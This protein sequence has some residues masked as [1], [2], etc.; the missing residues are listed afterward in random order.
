MSPPDEDDPDA[1]E[2]ALGTLDAAE[3]A[4]ADM[5]RR[6]DRGFDASVVQWEARLSPLNEAF[7]E[8]APPSHLYARLMERLFGSGQPAGGTDP[9]RLMSL[10]R[11]V[12]RW[13]LATGAMTALAAALLA[14]VLIE[15]P[16]AA[17]GKFVA[18]LQRDANSPAM[19]LDVDIAARR[20]TIRPVS[21]EEPADKS[22]QL[23]LINPEVGGARS[24]GL[25]SNRAL[26]QASL[27]DYDP[28]VIARATYAVTLEPLGGSPT[29]AP[30]GP[31]ILSG[32]LLNAGH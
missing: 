25:L 10:T 7:P 26:T 9:V 5:R 30:S 1:A 24:L 22:L 14:F 8:L 18:V 19:I 16:P 27:K 32:K 15:P 2:Y 23:W 12:R 4:A 21:T 3:R 20:L 29:G 28:A 31:P 6:A 13:R 17:T 11:S